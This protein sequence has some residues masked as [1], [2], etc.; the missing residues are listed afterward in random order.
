[1]GPPFHHN[2][3]NS[4]LGCPPDSLCAELFVIAGPTVLRGGAA[5]VRRSASA[6]AL[7][8]PTSSGAS[9]SSTGPLQVG[10]QGL[11]QMLGLDRLFGDFASATTGFLSRSRS[12]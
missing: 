2:N 10:D 6:D 12:M 3:L 1:M 7:R 8:E 11:F 5:A 9:S 4:V